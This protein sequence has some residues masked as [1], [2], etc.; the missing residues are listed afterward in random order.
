M[1]LDVI[2]KII[3]KKVAIENDFFFKITKNN[4]SLKAIFNYFHSFIFKRI[5]VT[6]KLNFKKYLK[7]EN[8]VVTILK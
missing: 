3:L 1:F 5:V 4:F 7:N 8:F 6:N 2:V